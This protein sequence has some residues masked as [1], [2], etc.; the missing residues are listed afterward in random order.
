MIKRVIVR[1]P[2]KAMQFQRLSS[3]THINFDTVSEILCIYMCLNHTSKISNV[4]QLKVLEPLLLPFY[5]R[6]VYT[7]QV[8]LFKLHVIGV[9]LYNVIGIT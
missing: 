9:Y 2:H 6:T 3:E 5:Y 1:Q 8:K 7:S 4:Y